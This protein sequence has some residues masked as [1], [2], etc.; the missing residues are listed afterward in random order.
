MNSILLQ[1]RKVAVQLFFVMLSL[2]AGVYFRYCLE[3]DNIGEPMQTVLI[4]ATTALFLNVAIL[5]LDIYIQYRQYVHIQGNYLGY[6]FRNNDESNQL[7]T[8]SDSCA[9]ITYMGGNEFKIKL[10]H[11]DSLD[12][13]WE[14]RMIMNGRGEASIAWKY[15]K[16]PKKT[17]LENSA[18]YKKAVLVEEKKIFM[19]SPDGQHFGREVLI[20]KESE[21]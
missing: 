3:N 16:W 11:G 15:T 14:G 9:E 18:G 13:T 4:S 12:H 1:N 20:K 17:D 10:T 2:V 8:K 19:F 7:K 5:I 6:S 21:K